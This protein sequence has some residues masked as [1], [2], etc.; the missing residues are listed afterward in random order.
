[1]LDSPGGL[2]FPNIQNGGLYL[3]STFVLLWGDIFFDTG[4]TAEVK[5]EKLN[6]TERQTWVQI[7]TIPL[8]LCVPV[9]ESLYLRDSGSTK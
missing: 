5:R 8:I 7:L 2:G 3:T 1:M 4:E 6:L 9:G